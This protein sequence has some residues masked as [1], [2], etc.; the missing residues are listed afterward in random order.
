MYN[1]TAY[2]ESE[3]ATKYPETE[4]QDWLLA[5][6]RRVGG[7]QQHNSFKVLH[8][9]GEGTDSYNGNFSWNWVGESGS[10]P[11]PLHVASSDYRQYV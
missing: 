7:G 8:V 3:E 1:A 9:E 4:S 10:D 6:V 11:D 2:L 5:A